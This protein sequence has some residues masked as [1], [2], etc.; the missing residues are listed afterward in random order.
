MAITQE[1][2]DRL[3]A[4][5]EGFAQRHPGGYRIRVACLA[6]LGYGYI[7]LVLAGIITLLGLL[8]WLAVASRRLNKGMI[9]L[10]AGL[11]ASAWVLLRKKRLPSFQKNAFASWESCAIKGFWKP[12]PPP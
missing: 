4:R 5:L 1:K 2:F 12:I 7:F 8:V 11:A 9:M 10:G 3:I 6:M